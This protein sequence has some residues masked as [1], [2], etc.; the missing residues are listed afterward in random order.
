MSEQRETLLTW[1]V[2]NW[3][4]IILMVTIGFFL[5]GAAGNFLRSFGASRRTEESAAV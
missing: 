1:N 3:I 2:P 5:L 4:T